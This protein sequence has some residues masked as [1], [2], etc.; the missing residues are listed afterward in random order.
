MVFVTAETGC[1]Y[2][3]PY[4]CGAQ[5]MAPCPQLCQRKAAFDEYFEVGAP[6][7]LRSNL[8]IEGEAKEIR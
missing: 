3:H 7:A 2:F 6:A 1:S 4:T 5:V 8:G